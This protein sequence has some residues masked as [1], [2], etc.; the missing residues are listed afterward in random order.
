[1]TTTP[2]ESPPVPAPFEDRRR[3]I[4]A[5]PDRPLRHT[6]LRSIV[7]AAVAVLLLRII[8]G[9]WALPT[10]AAFPET[11]L[12]QTVGLA[13]GSA[14]IGVWLQRVAVMPWMRYD[15]E[16]YR[17]IVERGYEPN[18]GRAAF[19]PLYPLLTAPIAWLLGGN[20]L[21]AL[22][23]VATLATIGLSVVFTRYVEEVHGGKYSQIA[24]WLLLVT[25]PA[26]ILLAPYNES[27]F[28]ALAVGV[29]WT[30]HRR[31]WWLAGLLGGLAALT[32]QQG[33]ALALPL[34][35]GLF[36]ALRERRAR[37][38]DAAALGLIPLGYGL[39]VVYRAV[40]LGDLAALERAQGPADFLRTLLVSRLS[41]KVEPGQRIAWPWEPL[42]DV[43]RLIPVAPYSYYLVID[44][45]LGWAGALV[46]L[47]GL[48]RMTMA[49]RLY[50]LAIVVLSLC[51][52]N[53][54]RAPYLSLPRHILLAF[55]LF[56]LLAR[57][58]GKGRRYRMFFLLALLGNLFLA[59]LF[60]RRS[61]I[62]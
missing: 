60:V 31:R 16:H 3:A 54:Y 47:L 13:P 5:A 40:A 55:P 15:A 4:G 45:A 25:P 53:G 58:A 50:S 18:E 17:T 39:F 48:R 38:W 49:E 56:I 35:W 24:G 20:T 61:W 10:S 23:L 59:G 19:H 27:L 62:P 43:I 28:L 44:L 8:L 9:L 21:L 51:Y 1:M 30:T 14:P 6:G 33:L 42:I 22:L 7:G 29:L 41:E 12:E 37:I 36:V 57:W 34:A 2:S 26:F 46:V 11:E 52:Y 32:R